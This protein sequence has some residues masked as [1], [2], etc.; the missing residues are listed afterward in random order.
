[1]FAFWIEALLLNLL[2]FLIGIG[3][4]WLIWGRDAG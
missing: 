1:M 2:L 4:A 3:I